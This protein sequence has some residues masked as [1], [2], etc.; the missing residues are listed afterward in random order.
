MCS[1]AA[2]QALFLSYRFFFR[3]DNC[4]LKKMWC[5][6]CFSIF[7]EVYS[8]ELQQIFFMLFYALE[9][10]TLVHKIIFLAKWINQAFGM[11]SFNL[12]KHPTTHPVYM[13]KILEINKLFVEFAFG[14]L[15]VLKKKPFLGSLGIVL[16]FPA[17]DKRRTSLILWS[18]PFSGR[19]GS[20]W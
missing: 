3:S 14:V 9:M 13:G 6:Y 12:K 17:Q 7:L 5:Q 2:V 16:P 18:L 4:H 19:K 8:A 11:V 10:Q 15:L 1:E 20:S